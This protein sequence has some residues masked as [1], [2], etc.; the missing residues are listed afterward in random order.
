MDKPVCDKC[1]RPMYFNGYDIDPSA[2][3]QMIQFRCFSLN[4]RHDT[5]LTEPI[6]DWEEFRKERKFT[7]LSNGRR[8]T[9]SKRRKILTMLAQIPKIP[10]PEISKATGFST[11]IICRMK[12]ITM[13]AAMGTVL[14]GMK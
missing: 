4:N 11:P 5:Y 6:P 8:M 2:G 7:P 10:Y 3:L 1:A 9:E 14:R 13:L 12:Q